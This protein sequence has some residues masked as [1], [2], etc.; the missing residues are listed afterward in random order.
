MG[1]TTTDDIRIKIMICYI[2][3]DTYV[4]RGGYSIHHQATSLRAKV[5]LFLGRVKPH[6]DHSPFVTPNHASQAARKAVRR[7]L[8]VYVTH[9]RTG[10]YEQLTSTHP[11]LSKASK[12]ASSMAVK[13][14]KSRN[15][16]LWPTQIN[17]DWEK[18]WN[19]TNTHR[20]ETKLTYVNMYMI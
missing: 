12:Q 5:E 1:V 11:D 10:A 19:R 3:Y 18:A 6:L 4:C 14:Q 15:K 9:V 16:P 7:V 8:P 13:K 17:T 2:N 20:A